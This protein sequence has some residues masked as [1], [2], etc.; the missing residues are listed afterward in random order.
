LYPI[1]CVSSSRV[2]RVPTTMVYFVFSINLQCKHEI[3]DPIYIYIYRKT[4]P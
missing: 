1:L 3:E 4:V 2:N